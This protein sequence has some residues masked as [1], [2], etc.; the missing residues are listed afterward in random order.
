MG[1]LPHPDVLGKPHARPEPPCNQVLQRSARPPC[2]TLPFPRHRN[3]PV[4]TVRYDGTIHDFMML[5]P[6]AETN[7]TRAAVAQAAAPLHAA[8]RTGSER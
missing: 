1:V 5:N 3:L 7:A 8:L 2:L 6:V 4:T